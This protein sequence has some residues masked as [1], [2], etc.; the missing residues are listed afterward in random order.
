MLL[1]A[2]INVNPSDSDGAKM[3]GA[4][5]FYYI[6]IWPNWMELRP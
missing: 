4:L 6:I 3:G 1:C 2:K 5:L